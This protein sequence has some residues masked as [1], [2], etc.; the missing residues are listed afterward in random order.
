[1]RRLLLGMV[2]GLAALPAGAASF[3]SIVEKVESE[4]GVRKVHTA[5]LG[6]LVN[7]FVFVRRP[8]GASSLNFATFEG[9]HPRF[10]AAVR[11]AAG[12]DWK[13][14]VSVH[15]KRDNEDVVIYVRAEGNKFELLLATS[16]AHDATLV[17]LKLDGERILDWL[18]DPVKMNV[19]VSSSIQ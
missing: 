8:G 2:L 5:G 18:R 9:G 13:P 10:Q 14:M 11:R 6:V 16:D 17:Q 1:V 15:S 3:H 12:R 7:S 19:N 4:I